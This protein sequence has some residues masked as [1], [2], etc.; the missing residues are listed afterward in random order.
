MTTKVKQKSKKTVT[1]DKEEYEALL[2]MAKV[3]SEYLEGK[4]E[5]FNSA[6]DLISNLKSL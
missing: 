3:T 5:S 1:I 4:V 6:D 2:H